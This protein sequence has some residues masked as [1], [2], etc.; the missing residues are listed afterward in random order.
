MRV[1]LRSGSTPAPPST[2]GDVASEPWCAEGALPGDEAY[3]GEK[4]AACEGAVAA[5]REAGLGREEDEGSTEERRK[6]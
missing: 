5:G 4:A 1:L 2:V 6:A 3:E